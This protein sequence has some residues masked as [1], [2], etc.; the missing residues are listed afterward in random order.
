[1]QGEEKHRQLF[2]LKQLAAQLLAQGCLRV[3]ASV[4]M[5]HER[6][7]EK[8]QG[9]Q[10]GGMAPSWRLGRVPSHWGGCLTS[11]LYFRTLNP[12]A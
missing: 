4:S 12:K 8:R 9:P 11:L 7:Q 2:F 5:S 3:G 1:M 10:L 6:Q